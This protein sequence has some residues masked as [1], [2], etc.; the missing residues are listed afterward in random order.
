MKKVILLI[1][2]ITLMI[3]QSAYAEDNAVNVEINGQLIQSEDQNFIEDGRVF[4]LARDISEALGATVDWVNDTKEI[5]VTL[6]E[7]KVKFNID[8]FTANANGEIKVL[9]VMPKFINSR[10]YVPIRF[11]SENLGFNVQWDNERK[12]V[13]ITNGIFETSRGETVV[14]STYTKDDL[15]WLSRIVQVETGGST[16]DMKMAVA[17]VVLNRVKDSR[18]PDSV[19]DVIFQIDTYVQFPPAHRESFL[20]L[21][22]SDLSIDA[23]RRAL[24]GENTISDCLYFNN[25]PFKS[26]TD[27]L[28]KVIDGEYFYH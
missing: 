4:V 13:V 27:D 14:E 3:I 2:I 28:Y 7:R 18:F 12:L 20:T 23:A 21:I 22:P 6:E 15:L 25:S 24:E 17:N 26:K 16:I 19:H 9:D 8:S 1:S 5:S 10:S 11:L